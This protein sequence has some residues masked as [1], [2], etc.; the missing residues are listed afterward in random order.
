MI[1]STYRFH[2]SICHY[3]MP[4][5]GSTCR[6]H[7]FHCH[8]TYITIRDGL[9]RHVSNCHVTHITT[10]DGT[11]TPRIHFPALITVEILPCCIPLPEFDALRMRLFG[12][13]LGS[14]RMA[15]ES[16]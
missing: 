9:A 2:V 14:T 13:S 15:L 5:L 8:V 7:P 10:R 1:G 6:F 12:I 3:P 16:V 11:G 4:R